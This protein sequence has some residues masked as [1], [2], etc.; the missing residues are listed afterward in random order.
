MD[1]PDLPPAL[2]LHEV[3]VAYGTATALEGIE[4]TVAPGAAVALVGPNGAGK[5]T[6]LKA[7]LGLVPVASGRITVLGRTPVE[8]RRDVSYVPQADTLDP[9]FPISAGQVV[10]MGRYRGLGRLRRPTAADRQ[11][12]HDALERVGLA[13]R[14][15]HRFGT[16]SGGQRQRVLLARAIA[17]RP[18]LLLLDEPFNGVDAVSEEAL[19]R[20][21]AH[22]REEG[23]TAVIA[24]HDLALARL[25]CTGIWLL[26]RRQYGFGPTGS[27]LTADRLRA[28]YGGHAV[29]PH[30]LEPH[31]DRFVVAPPRT[32]HP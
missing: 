13:G 18:R 9:E 28:A 19:L 30:A 25:A 5:S 22:M 23:T 12:V 6:L 24:T 15:G 27:V 2:D 26:N 11:A 10:L 1:T 31:D 21:I 3:R 16:L 8:A 4:G 14:A 17:A 29:E 32:G 20:S 7:V